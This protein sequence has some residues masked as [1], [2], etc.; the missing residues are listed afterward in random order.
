MDGIKAI[1]W[2]RT[3]EKDALDHL[4]CNYN[5]NV[6]PTGVWLTNSGLL[7]ASPDGL[8]DEEEAIVEVKC[9]YSF[10]NDQLSEKLKNFNKYIIF[11]DDEGNLILNTSHNYYH[12]IQGALH[13]LKKK[14]C[15]LCIYT[16]KETI[17][18][19]VD[20]DDSWKEN[21]SI[22]ENFYIEQYLPKLLE[23]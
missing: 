8:I 4:K 11:Y 9:P 21:L 23:N 10:R 3:H 17:V 5:L 2:G 13:I 6:R 20:L 15:Y 7:G 14:K 12:Q 19:I 1:Q 16:L 18:T 22:L